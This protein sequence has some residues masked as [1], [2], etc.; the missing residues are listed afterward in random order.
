[1]A[2]GTDVT[3]CC[4]GTGGVGARRT[5]KEV[6]QSQR[7]GIAKWAG[8]P[9]EPLHRGGRDSPLSVG[10]TGKMW[11]KHRG[12]SCRELL[13]GMQLWGVDGLKARTRDP[14]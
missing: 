4:V 6:S 2:T 12:L 7:I 13:R 3:F 1:M 14:S 9:G 11:A 5:Q 8:S 10:K